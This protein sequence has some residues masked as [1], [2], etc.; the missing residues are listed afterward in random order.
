[1]WKSPRS[2]LKR[3]IHSQGKSPNPGL[4][5]WRK[6]EKRSIGEES[7]KRHVIA[8]KEGT[9]ESDVEE[10]VLVE[11]PK[12]HGKEVEEEKLKEKIVPRN[13]KI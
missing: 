6:L 3:Q 10:V 5:R 4:K 1:M 8:D 13:E 11:E 12:Y 9:I 7:R 2:R